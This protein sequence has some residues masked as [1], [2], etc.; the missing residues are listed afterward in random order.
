MCAL[1]VA[2]ACNVGLVPIEKPNVPVLH[3]LQYISDSGYR[4]MIGTQLNVQEARHRLARKI[5]FGNRGQLRQRYREGME[6]QL[7]TLGLALNA[8]VWWNSLYLD[9]A[10]KDLRAQGFPATDEMCARLSPIQYDHINSWAVTPS[11]AP[12]WPPG[13]APSTPTST[14]RTEQFGQAGGLRGHEAR[15]LHG[16]SFARMSEVPCAV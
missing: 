8:V 7:G 14:R 10:V 1:V 4:R 12:T 16:R 13:C 11:P 9:A 2:E 15:S 3:L 5:A 6:D